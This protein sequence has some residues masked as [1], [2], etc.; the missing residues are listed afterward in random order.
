MAVRVFPEVQDEL[1]EILYFGGAAAQGSDVPAALHRLEKG[2]VAHQRVI[3]EPAD[4]SLPDPALRYIEDAAAGDLVLSVAD[5]LEVSDH[6]ADLPAVVEVRAADHVVGDRG[7]HEPL[8]KRARLRVGAV[9]NGEIPVSEVPVLPAFALDVLSNK[10]CFVPCGHKAAEMEF[11]PRPPVRPEC[12]ALP[13]AVVAD[14]GVRR[15]EHVLGRPVVLL[16]LDDEGVRIYLFKI[17]NVPDIRPP[18]AVDGL[19]VVADDAEIPVFCR[20]KTH[21]LELGLVGVLVLVHHDVAEPVLV[22]IQHFVVGMEELHRQHEE[23]VK[24]YR[25]V[26]PQPLLVLLVGIRDLLVPETQADHLFSEP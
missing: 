22:I 4:R 1:Y 24:I 9:Q 3:G 2:D 19:V 21:Q 6:V 15:V 26:L 7:Q 18:E 23:V 17:E 14:H 8:L 20:E 5:R 13:A 25:V 10:G 12:F 11:G 16:E